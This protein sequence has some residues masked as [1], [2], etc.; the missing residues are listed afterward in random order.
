MGAFLF[1]CWAAWAGAAPAGPSEA[2]VATVSDGDSLVLADGRAL[3]LIGIN[4]PEL[5]KDGTPDEPLARAARTELER[6]VAGK[7]VHLTLDE[8]HNDRYGRLLA[9]VTLLDGGSVAERLLEQGLA[10]VIAV[11]PNLLNLARHLDVEASAR[12]A[13]RGLWGHAYFMPRAAD[14]LHTHD[15]GFRFV[16]GRVQRVGESRNNV[17]LDLGERLSVMIAHADWQRYFSG[18]P[19]DYLHQT[20]E[21]RGWVTEQNDKLRI[22]VH[23]PAMIAK[24]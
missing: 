19:A 2:R 16:H 11:S 21:V 1:S 20:I 12:R 9:H 4:A 7:R 24:P 14:A 8:E 13:K 15:T 22:R 3:R 18:R 23:H 5:G 17:Y 6:L 10:C